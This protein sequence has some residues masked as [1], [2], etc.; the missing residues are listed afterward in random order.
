MR[1]FVHFEQTNG[2]CEI[3][4][5]RSLCT[6]YDSPINKIFSR[7]QSCQLINKY[8]R[9]RDHLCPHHQGYDGDR[10]GPWNVNNF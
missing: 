3:W 2:F 6:N 5:E 9:F 4:Y 1:V 8:R 7:C 10:D